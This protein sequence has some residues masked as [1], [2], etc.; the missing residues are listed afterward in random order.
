[1]S[2]ITGSL[3]VTRI[4]KKHLFEGRH[5]KYLNIR[6]IPNR[7]GPDQYG[8]THFVVQEVS[9]ADYEAG[10]K[11]PIIGNLKIVEDEQQYRQPPPPKPALPARAT[12]RPQDLAFE[13]KEIEA[14]MEEDD[15]PF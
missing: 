6:A 9:K 15:I 11:G 14:P 12:L 3:N 10:V 1:M 4:E 5:G 2:R 7:N 13:E 8:N